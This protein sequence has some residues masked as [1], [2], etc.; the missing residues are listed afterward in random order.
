MVAFRRDA[1][2]I[3]L[4]QI[5]NP[6]GGVERLVCCLG[7]PGQE[8]IEPSFPMAVLTHFLEQPVVVSAMRFEKQAEIEERLLQHAVDTKIE[9]DQQPADTA[10]AVKKRVYGLELDV[11][12]PGLDEGRKARLV[13]VHE[14]FKRPEAFIK[15][16]DGGRHK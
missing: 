13:L 8:E 14:A 4:E 1:L 15:F 10:I 16:H 12:Q 5:D 9:R 7:H 6:R 11:Q 2:A 3:F